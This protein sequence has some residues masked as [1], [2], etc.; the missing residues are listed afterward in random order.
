[1]LDAREG[2]IMSNIKTK[3]AVKAVIMATSIFSMSTL[4]SQTLEEIV[5]TAQIR[6]QSLQDVPISVS[7]LSGESIEDRSIDNLSSLA[8]SVPNFYVAETQIDTS[9]SIR[10]VV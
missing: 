6:E 3:I 10:G 7:A 4:L 5:V 8:T 1:M 2:K 9:I